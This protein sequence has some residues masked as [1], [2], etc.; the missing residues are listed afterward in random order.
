MHRATISLAIDIAL[1]QAAEEAAKRA[2]ITRSALIRRC[3]R[4]TLDRGQRDLDAVTTGG[5]K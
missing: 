5:A 2:G 1:L 3:V 4:E